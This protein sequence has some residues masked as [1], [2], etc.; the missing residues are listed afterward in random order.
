MP[1]NI[2]GGACPN[3]GV[4]GYTLNGGTGLIVRKYVYVYVY[5]Y[6]HAYIYM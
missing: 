6:V 2:I 5:V 3:V 1:W 4:G